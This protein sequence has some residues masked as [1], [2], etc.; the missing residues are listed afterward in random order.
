MIW[1]IVTPPFPSSDAGWGQRR[2]H[3]TT[4]ALP[5]SP[6]SPARARS[7][8]RHVSGSYVL[9][10]AWVSRW[11]HSQ[12]APRP[13]MWDRSALQSPAVSSIPSVS[14]S[15]AWGEGSVSGGLGRRPRLLGSGP[16]LCRRWVQEQSSKVPLP[17]AAGVGAEG[18]AARADAAE[19]GE[20]A[21]RVGARS[22][23]AARRFPAAVVAAAAA[24]T[25]KSSLPPAGS[26][27]QRPERVAA[28]SWSCT[29][30]TECGG[31]RCG[32]SRGS[33]SCSSS[34]S[35]SSQSSSLRSASW[36]G[37]GGGG[38]GDAARSGWQGRLQAGRTMDAAAVQK[39]PA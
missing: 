9:S 34:S 18:I 19:R 20:P 16:H 10:L 29:V 3:R 33:A 14:A 21:L 25:L 37:G 36:G 35:S 31:P 22:G 11:S 27:A 23:A 7:A 15:S 30:A 24:R 4:S 1:C 8:G 12:P 26:H 28:R 17:R 2:R 32:R 5:P 13:R 38:L 6:W 39:R